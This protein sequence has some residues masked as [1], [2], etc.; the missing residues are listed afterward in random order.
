[1]SEARTSLLLH[2]VRLRVLQAALGRTVTTSELAGAMPDV[3]TA[4]LYRHV[5]A[6]VDGG[7]LEVAAER[8][9]RGGTER[10]LRVA[11]PA[12]SLGPENI[13]HLAA[14]DHLDGI[15]AFLGGVLQAATD[16]LAAPGATP[17]DDGFGY[18]QVA[19]WADDEELAE[20]VA[21]LREVVAEAAER[22]PGA[23]RR[24]RVLTT[25]LLPDPAP[26]PSR[27]ASPPPPEAGVDTDR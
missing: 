26:H 11:L 16:Y 20:L 23:G 6:L 19:L 14:E 18:R 1:V 22:G 5:A 4:S 25:V 17:A 13:A 21:R 7:V 9:V 8:A 27:D 12:A 15:T 10:T 24:R 2:P 3:P